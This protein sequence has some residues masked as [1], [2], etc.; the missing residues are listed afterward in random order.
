MDEK[1]R[2]ASELVMNINNIL[3]CKPPILYPL[4]PAQFV[5]LGK[6]LHV[7]TY[8]FV[9]T[10]MLA[11]YLKTGGKNHI[12]SGQ[13]IVTKWLIV[14]LGFLL[15]L[16]VSDSV[17]YMESVFTVNSRLFHTY[18]S[19]RIISTIGL[20][21]F[22]VSPLFFPTILYGLPMIPPAPPTSSNTAETEDYSGQKGQ[23]VNMKVIEEEYLKQIQDKIESA[24]IEEKAYLQKDL[25]LTQLSVLTQIPVHHLAYFFREH[26]GESFHDFR[27]KWRVEYA[28]KLIR[29][30]KSRGMTLE[31]IGHMSG[32]TSRNTF[33]ISF[34][35]IEGISPGEYVRKLADDSV[36]N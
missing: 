23:K 10:W 19:L 16:A 20:V 7:L 17:F 33:F 3:I 12:M 1:L 30:G 36:S 9:S 27:N 22:V 31:A 26:L 32:F 8:T 11:G 35:R 2:I 25:N 21:G 6:S 5:F 18:N 13:Q 14:L 29:E 4:I 15:I 28:K 24:M 34:K